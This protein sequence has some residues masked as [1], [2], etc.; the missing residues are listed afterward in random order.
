MVSSDDVDRRE[1]LK[2]SSAAV[3]AL[4][5]GCTAD[6]EGDGGDGGSAQ[7]VNAKWGGFHLEDAMCWDCVAPSTPYV[8]PDRLRQR[9]D[10]RFDVTFTGG[11]EIC[12]ESDC[13]PKLKNELVE[14]GS[15]AIANAT[16]FASGLNIWTLPYLF[17]SRTAYPY[18]MFSEESWQRFWVPFAKKHGVVPVSFDVPT[19]RQLFIGKDTKYSKNPV[20][21]PSDINNAEIRR[22]AAKATGTTL[23]KWG[24]SPVSIPFTDAVEGMR[25]GV[26]AGMETGDAYGFTFGVIG[27]SSQVVVNNW[28]TD[29]V[30]HWADVDWLDGLSAEDRELFAEVT[31]KA[32]EE[33]VQKVPDLVE[34][35]MGL[36]ENPPGGS[37]AAKAGVDVH[38]LT[39][40]ETEKW[41]KPVDPIENKNLFSWAIEDGE[42]IAGDG[43]LQYI[44]DTAQGS[45]APKKLSDAADFTLDSWWNDHLQE[46]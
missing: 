35:Q 46:I 36:V 8:I 10:G 4:L 21:V 19:F 1:L 7:P 41:R 39:E 2:L 38:V 13:I 26:V 25:T 33:V 20:R 16:A 23:E 24:A 44:V 37:A 28:A 34:T 15:T 45:K 6:Q 3:P 40:A 22:T 42:K 12:G 11:S 31:K 18:T 5:A 9:T 32:S 14:L 27:V 30:V 43:F 29:Y 17:P